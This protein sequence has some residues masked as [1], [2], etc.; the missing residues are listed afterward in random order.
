[1]KVIPELMDYHF[2]LPVNS[3]ENIHSGTEHP[4]CT[5]SIKKQFQNK[6]V[7]NLRNQYVDMKKENVQTWTFS[8]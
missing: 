8:K 7:S 4:H 1:M 5:K 2:F 6:K 3:S